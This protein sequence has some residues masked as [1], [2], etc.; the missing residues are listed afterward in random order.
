VQCTTCNKVSISFDP[1]NMLSLPIPQ[2]SKDYRTVIRY[3]P[4]SLVKRP[5][6][7]H[8]ELGEYATISEVR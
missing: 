6:E 1:F 8:F 5:L 4:L 3:Y 2:P 7:L